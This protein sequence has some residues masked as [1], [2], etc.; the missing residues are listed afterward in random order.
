[1][2]LLVRCRRSTCARSIFPHSPWLVHLDATW[3]PASLP[4]WTRFQPGPSVGFVWATI[5]IADFLD[6]ARVIENLLV[7]AGVP[8]QAHSRASVTRVLQRIL[9]EAPHWITPRPQAAAVGK[10][11]CYSHIDGSNVKSLLHREEPFHTTYID[12]HESPHL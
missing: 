5:I 9:L 8:L 2:E 12:A 10:S 3:S 11:T 1:M 4:S 7:R 6:R